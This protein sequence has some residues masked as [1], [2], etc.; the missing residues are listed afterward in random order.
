MLN[1]RQKLSN[2]IRV[3]SD[4]L[5]SLRSTDFEAFRALDD[6]RQLCMEY[7]STPQKHRA[8]TPEELAY[9]SQSHL[10]LTESEKGD[11]QYVLDL[12]RRA[13]QNNNQYLR[14]EC[15]AMAG[16]FILQILNS[17]GW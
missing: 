8:L 12:H 9:F 7:L 2:T 11:L 15:R 17:K 1:N 3:L 4:L 6:V 5:P 14:Q 13:I 10:R 16:D